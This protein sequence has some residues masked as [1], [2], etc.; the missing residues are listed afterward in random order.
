MRS[1]VAKCIP[2]LV[3]IFTPPRLRVNLFLPFSVPAPVPRVSPR[4]NLFFGLF[5]IL[6]VLV[7]VFRERPLLCFF[8]VSPS[9]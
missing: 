4:V 1:V 6:R 7:C 5:R 3:R 9:A 2:F 8:S